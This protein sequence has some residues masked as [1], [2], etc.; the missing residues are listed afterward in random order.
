MT[1][2]KERRRQ[3]GKEMRV[4]GALCERKEGKDAM[5]GE[6]RGSLFEGRRGMMEGMKK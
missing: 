3:E 4:E 2:G 1:R 6:N 5:E